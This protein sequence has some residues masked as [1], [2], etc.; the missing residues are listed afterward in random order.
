MSNDHRVDTY[1][2][3]KE[4]DIEKRQRDR[5]EE[6]RKRKDKREGR[7]L[8]A[9]RKKKHMRD[10]MRSTKSRETLFLTGTASGTELLFLLNFC[11]L[12]FFGRRYH[13]SLRNDLACKNGDLQLRDLMEVQVGG[14]RVIAFAFFAFPPGSYHTR[15]SEEEAS[16]IRERLNVLERRR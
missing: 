13:A 15:T 5:N 1:M 16:A 8:V 9:A 7:V 6:D 12:F 11:F 3:E 14:R 2:K 10:V 4:Q